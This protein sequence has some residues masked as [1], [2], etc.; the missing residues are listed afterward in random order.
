M[1]AGGDSS[2]WGPR[3]ETSEGGNKYGR[4]VGEREGGCICSVA[5]SCRRQVTGHGPRVI[6]P[7]KAYTHPRTVV[8]VLDGDCCRVNPHKKTTMVRASSFESHSRALLRPVERCQATFASPR[9][10]SQEYL[11]QA[12]PSVA[13]F[14]ASRRYSLNRQVGAKLC[15]VPNLRPPRYGVSQ[16]SRR[17]RWCAA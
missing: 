3:F 9:R 17:P 13:T 6:S 5:G 15:A 12:L 11:G 1:L 4:R 14:Q 7:R 8:V 10:T 2:N 16:P